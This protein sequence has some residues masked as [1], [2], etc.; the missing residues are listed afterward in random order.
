MTA[1]EAKALGLHSLNTNLDWADAGGG[2]GKM[3]SRRTSVDAN[4]VGDAEIVGS[5]LLEPFH[6]RSEA[7]CLSRA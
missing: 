5:C 7:K 1:A 6:E 3:Q 4:R 2:Q